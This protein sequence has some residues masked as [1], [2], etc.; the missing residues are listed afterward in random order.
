M[1]RLTVL[2]AIFF[3]LNAFGDN[4][5]IQ[6][7]ITKGSSEAV[8]GARVSLK[9]HPSIAVLTGSDGSFTLTGNT[10]TLVSPWVK[11]A[12]GISVRT[13][14]NGAGIIIRM[15]AS[16]SAGKIDVYKING[17]IVASKIFDKINAA[18]YAVPF[19]HASSEAYLVKVSTGNGSRLFKLVPGL[20]VSCAVLSDGI[21]VSGSTGLSKQAASVSDSLVVFAN[22]FKTAFQ[23]L[24]SYATTD[25]A[26]SLTASN[27]WVPSVT[28][29]HSKSM[30]KIKAK[31]YDFEMGQPDE[32]ILG[33]DS[34]G[35]YIASIEVPPH[36]VS[37]AHDFWMDTVEVTQAEFDSL[38]KIYYTN[39]SQPQW[40]A[41]MGLGAKC[42]ATMTN[43]A[44]AALFCNA[45][46]KAEGLDT[47][48]AF[49]SISGKPGA[50]TCALN[51]VSVNASSKGYRLPTEAEWEYAYRGGTTT[52][53]CWGKNVSD[54][55]TATVFT[56]VDSY[57][58]WKHNSFDK[59]SGN[60]GFGV[61]LVGTTTPNKYGLYEM[62]GN[63]SEWCHDEFGEYKWGVVT[64]SVTKVSTMDNH[65]LR[66]GNWSNDILY[67]RTV[68]RSFNDKAQ[69]FPFL[70]GFR[71]ARTAED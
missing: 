69:Y 14:R 1:K 27:L 28:P 52:D 32:T 31:G 12:A 71:L 39:Y 15:D 50:I 26:I 53:Y 36:T 10:R 18:E 55:K 63:A 23:A 13:M 5:N 68:C 16:Q 17:R 40:T 2:A 19:N 38:M 11:G 34:T 58:V 25:I 67:L 37:F 6:G 43:W 59:G 7:K 62:A 66:G 21:A 57:A 35:Y 51:N 47:V 29:E 42:P 3:C 41:V 45:R 4:I 48:Y 46:S 20:S 60:P 65:A 54:Y 56:D 24:T 8:S 9:K 49:K 64:D 61:H 22:G 30:V 44:C 33:K 70:W